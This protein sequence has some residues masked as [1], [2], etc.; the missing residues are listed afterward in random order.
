MWRALRATGITGAERMKLCRETETAST[1][2]TRKEFGQVEDQLLRGASEMGSQGV[3]GL[4]LITPV[5]APPEAI[6]ESADTAEEGGP[7]LRRSHAIFNQDVHSKKISKQFYY[8]CLI[9]K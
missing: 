9:N 5:A 1:W 2:L 7:T 6:A 8:I 4:N 3:P